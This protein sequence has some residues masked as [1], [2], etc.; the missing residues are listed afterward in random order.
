MASFPIRIRRL[1]VTSP[2]NRGRQGRERSD[3]LVPP[4]CV[5]AGNRS[6]AKPHNN[7]GAVFV[8]LPT[9][10]PAAA[11]LAGAG[12]TRRCSLEVVIGNE[13]WRHTCGAVYKGDHSTVLGSLELQG[14]NGSLLFGVRCAVPPPPPT[15]SIVLEFDQSAGTIQDVPEI[16]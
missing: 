6:L 1:A 14:A 11:T 2:I 13:I 10:F 3:I 7:R 16:I 8:L 5:D 12:L 9:A 15:V 4:R